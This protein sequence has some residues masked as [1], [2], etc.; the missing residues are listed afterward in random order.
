M[1]GHTSKYQ[2]DLAKGLLTHTQKQTSPLL[3]AVVVVSPWQEL[4][5]QREGR[6]SL[7]LFREAHWSKL[8]IGGVTLPSLDGP[9]G[10]HTALERGLSHKVEGQRLW[11]AGARGPAVGVVRAENVQVVI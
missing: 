3:T 9:S 7:D 10:L 11:G 1:Y 8:S 5:T 4:K 6:E 2:A